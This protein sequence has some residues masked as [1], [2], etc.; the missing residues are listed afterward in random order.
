MSPP[1][2][3]TNNERARHNLVLARPVLS[4][5]GSRRKDKNQRGPQQ[6]HNTGKREATTTE[7]TTREPTT[8]DGHAQLSTTS[9]LYHLHHLHHLG[10]HKLHY[11]QYQ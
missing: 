3:N 6:L 2:N 8:R 5:P 10:N 7:T 1:Y 4:V 9:H 11:N